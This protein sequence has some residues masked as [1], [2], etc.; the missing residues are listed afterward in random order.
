MRIGWVTAARTKFEYPIDKDININ[1]PLKLTEGYYNDNDL[2]IFTQHMKLN[3]LTVVKIFIMHLLE[4]IYN[5]KSA[6]G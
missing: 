3:G 4:E 1:A 6:I 5:W 2:F